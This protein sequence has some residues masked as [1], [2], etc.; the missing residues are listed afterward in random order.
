MKKESPEHT[1]KKMQAV[2]NSVSKIETALAKALWNRG[3]RY[4]KNDR[5][6]FGTPDLTFKQLRIAIFV[7]SEFWHGKNWEVRKYD[8]KSNQ[9]FW[10]EKIENNIMRDKIVNQNLKENGWYILRFW[11]KDIEGNLNECVKKIEEAKN[12]VKKNSA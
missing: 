12:K 10:Y 7:D 11:G 3:H 5:S 8:H 2:K 6:V 4:R 9:Q 1:R